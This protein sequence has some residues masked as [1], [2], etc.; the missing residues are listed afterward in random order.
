[1]LTILR[2]LALLDEAFTNNFVAVSLPKTNL[3]Q[4]PDID[5]IIIDKGDKPTAPSV[6]P[7]LKRK[8]GYNSTNFYASQEESLR[9]DKREKMV[10][11]EP[12]ASES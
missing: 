3:S 12:Q 7:A 5:I 4:R 6:L 9:V 8:V 10:V 2:S 11:D 1:M